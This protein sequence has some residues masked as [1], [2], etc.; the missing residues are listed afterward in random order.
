MPGVIRKRKHH[1]RISLGPLVVC[2]LLL[3][4]ARSRLS[5]LYLQYNK[6]LTKERDALKLEL[7]KNR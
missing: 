4:P 2:Q 1:L 3:Q 6:D 5:F 7:Y